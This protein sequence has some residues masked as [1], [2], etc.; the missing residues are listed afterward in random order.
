MEALNIKEDMN[1]GL[2]PG[3]YDLNAWKKYYFCHI[4]SLEHRMS[5]SDF[6]IQGFDGRSSSINCKWTCTRNV[7]NSQQTYPF[8]FC[9]H[10]KL[11]QINTQQKISVIY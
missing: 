1:N 10:S 8:V 3:C 11:L 4:I 2:H 5:E 7:A 6:W 9:E